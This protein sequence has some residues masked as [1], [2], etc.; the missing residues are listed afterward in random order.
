V[1]IGHLLARLWIR[2]AFIEEAST[3]YERLWKAVGPADPHASRAYCV[4]T[5]EAMHADCR[6]LSAREA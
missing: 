3:L 4:S 1:P 6:D 2:R 5:P